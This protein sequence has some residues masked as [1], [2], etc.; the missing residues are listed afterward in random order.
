MK[1]ITL[2]DQEYL[3]TLLRYD[4]EHGTL[5]WIPQL[6]KRCNNTRLRAGCY[7]TKGYRIIRIDDR[8]YKEHRVIWAMHNGPIPDGL[9]IDHVDRNTGNN[10]L[11]NLR[12]VTRSV[13][14]L[15]K[16]SKGV[17]YDKLR[18]KWKAQLTFNG[19]QV[20]NKRFDSYEEALSVYQEVKLKLF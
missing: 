7:T 5:H 6:G 16:N 10:K 2:P 3:N 14:H 20:L 9:D 18:H 12:L 11:E 17:T 15:N 8:L 13:N 4:P 19:K 1:S